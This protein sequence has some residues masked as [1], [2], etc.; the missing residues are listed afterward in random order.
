MHVRTARFGLLCIHPDDVFYFPYGL[1]GREDR[2]HW[3]LLSDAANEAVG[4]LQSTTDPELAIA[5]VSPRRFAP[6]YRVRVAPRELAAIGLDEVG[7]AYV[8]NVVAKHNGR[9]TANLRAPLILNLDR[10]LGRQVV[11]GDEQPVQWELAAP[12]VELRRS[13]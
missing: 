13:A 5:V 11:T 8:L 3:V 10:R 12:Q 7:Q 2:R 1:I 6:H 9:L 4:W